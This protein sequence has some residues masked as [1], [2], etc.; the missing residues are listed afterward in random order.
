MCYLGIL[1]KYTFNVVHLCN[2]KHRHAQQGLLPLFSS[3]RPLFIS[4]WR[5]AS[6]QPTNVLP[7]IKRYPAFLCFDLSVACFL[8]SS[9]LFAILPPIELLTFSILLIN[10]LW[11]KLFKL[12]HYLASDLAGELL[13]LSLF[14]GLSWWLADKTEQQQKASVMLNPKCFMHC[15]MFCLYF[16]FV[17][18]T[19]GQQDTLLEVLSPSCWSDQDKEITFGMALHYMSAPIV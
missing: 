17:K 12:C 4:W 2:K 5:S 19:T 3:Y 10:Q 16:A 1:K 15:Q 8:F 13:Q 9:K 11:F 18:R 7:V 14:S 6:Y